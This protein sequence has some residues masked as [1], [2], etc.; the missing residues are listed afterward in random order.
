MPIKENLDIIRS[1]IQ[2]ALKGGPADAV[3]LIAVTKTILPERIDELAALGITDI[4][5]NKIQEAERK[6]PA[7]KNIRSF[8]KHF[9]GHLQTNKVKKAV[10]L[11]DV[12]QAVDSEHLAREISKQAE[13]LNKT[14]ECL[15]EI[16]VSEEESK[17]G[18]DPSGIVDFINLIRVF[19]NIRIIGIMGM[20]PYFENPEEARP[21]FKR[22]KKCFEDAKEYN[23]NLS[24]LSMG[25]SNDYKIAVEEG[26][27]MLRIGTALFKV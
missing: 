16:K 9:I 11:F 20:A 3:T 5:E 15:V 4:A 2:A 7:I 21:Y 13:K 17:Y 8:K 14:Q 27:T 25:M 19:G 22:L 10:E 26:A 23:P 1:G 12:I 6:F 24:V 18:V